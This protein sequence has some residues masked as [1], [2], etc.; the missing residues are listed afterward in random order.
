MVYRQAIFLYPTWKELTAVAD[1]NAES[2]SSKFYVTE[3]QI[4][5]LVME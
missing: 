1:F 4:F 2:I 3:Y 5:G